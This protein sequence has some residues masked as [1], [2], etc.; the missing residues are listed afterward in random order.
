MARRAQPRIVRRAR[1]ESIRG[2]SSRAADRARAASG[3]RRL[4]AGLAVA[5]TAAAIVAVAFQRPAGAVDKATTTAAPLAEHELVR[6]EGVPDPV[7]TQGH[8]VLVAVTG[9]REALTDTTANRTTALR[10]ARATLQRRRVE[11]LALETSA[12]DEQR[13][14]ISA[15]NRDLQSLLAELDAAP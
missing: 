4:I 7:R 9:A 12:S 1:G 13:R 8:R 5:V 6:L 15:V 10:K 2:R 3:D 11:L 14:A